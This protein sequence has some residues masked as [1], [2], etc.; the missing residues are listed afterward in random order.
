MAVDWRDVMRLAYREWQ[1]H[2][3]HHDDWNNGIPTL[4]GDFG[5]CLK[6]L[7]W[8]NVNTPQVVAANYPQFWHGSLLTLEEDARIPELYNAEPW[9]WWD[10]IGCAYVDGPDVSDERVLEHLRFS[11]GA[12]PDSLTASM[13]RWHN[14]AADPPLMAKA[15]AM[16]YIAWPQRHNPDARNELRH[17][18]GRNAERF[19]T[20]VDQVRLEP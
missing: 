8:L 11:K 10:M 18:A 1:G 17:A 7:C 14:H 6:A 13:D 9:R 4:E 19:F 2:Y 16:L 5:S 12:L 20:L 15:K 3:V